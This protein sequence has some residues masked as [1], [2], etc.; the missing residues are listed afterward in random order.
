MF[1][2]LVIEIPEMFIVNE[3][4]DN[5]PYLKGGLLMGHPNVA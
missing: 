1:K 2:Y 3:A 5:L 4:V